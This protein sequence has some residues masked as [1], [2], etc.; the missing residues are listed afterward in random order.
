MQKV[1]LFSSLLYKDKI[2]PLSYNKSD[3]VD[4]ILKN[5]K[6]DETKSRNNWD[7]RSDLHHYYADWDNNYYDPLPLDQLALIYEDKVKQFIAGLQ[8]SQN[9][10]YN[11]SIENIAVNT[12]HMAEHDHLGFTDNYEGV[13][14]AIHYINYDKIQHGPTNFFNPLMFAQFNCFTNTMSQI[15]DSE[16]QDNSAY[17]KSWSIDCNEDDLLI[18]PSY[19]KHDVTSNVE[20]SK[21]R[22]VSALNIKF[23]CIGARQD[24]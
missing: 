5:Y 9:I 17:F 14:S 7:N 11:W 13:F 18:F 22:I 6:K 8:L 10:E 24:A 16:N 12:R 4:V 20:T 15:L 2:D 1:N 3:I 21:H 23:K 19:L